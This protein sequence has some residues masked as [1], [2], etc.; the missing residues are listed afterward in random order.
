MLMYAVSIINCE[1]LEEYYDNLLY[2][3]N[4]YKDIDIDFDDFKELVQNK[5]ILQIIAEIYE[6]YE[7]MIIEYIS[8]ETGG[9]IN[10]HTAITKI[11]TTLI[12]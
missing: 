10:Y 4:L 6:D 1:S 9:D 5:E 11:L 12:F 3:L 8:P 2:E 7:K